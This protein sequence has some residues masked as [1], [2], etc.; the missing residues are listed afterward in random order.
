MHLFVYAMHSGY[1]DAHT[2]MHSEPSP[3]G[4]WRRVRD[5]FP[6]HLRKVSSSDQLPASNTPH[7][8]PDLALCKALLSLDPTSTWILVKIGME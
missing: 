7:R 3:A 2:H 5:E 6:E 1:F 4:L 8:D